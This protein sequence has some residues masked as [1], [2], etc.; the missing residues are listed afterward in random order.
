VNAAAALLDRGIAAAEQGNFEQAA[1]LCGQAAD[2]D[3][4]SPAALLA[5]GQTHAVL[6]RFADAERYLGI[7]RVIAPENKKGWNLCRCCRAAGE[8]RIRENLECVAWVL[9]R[10]HPGYARVFRKRILEGNSDDDDEE[11]E[12]AGPDIDLANAPV[13]IR[14]FAEKRPVL[15]LGLGPGSEEDTYSLELTGVSERELHTRAAC[16]PCRA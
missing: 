13:A 14:Q 15:A 6:G 16:R 11:A 3:P 7:L 12:L 5:A 8:E 1:D 9:G 10:Q 4:N 2:A